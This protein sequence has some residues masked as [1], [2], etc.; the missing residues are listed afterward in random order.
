MFAVIDPGKQGPH[1][2]VVS[3]LVVRLNEVLPTVVPAQVAT[4]VREQDI[5]VLHQR[6]LY[7]VKWANLWGVRWAHDA[8]VVD[9]DVSVGLSVCT[10]PGIRKQLVLYQAHRLLSQDWS[11]ARVANDWLEDSPKKPWTSI[12]GLSR[13]LGIAWGVFTHSPELGKGRILLADGQAVESAVSGDSFLV[14]Q[15][16]NSAGLWSSTA[17]FGF[18]DM[19]GREITTD[20]LPLSLD[21]LSK[22]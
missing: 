14:F 5:H 8:D 16:F 13:G 6:T 2:D 21:S 12:V 22:L 19:Q 4:H 17:R 9:V 20:A 1:P 10:T 7:R 18:Y 11:I 3:S 15:P